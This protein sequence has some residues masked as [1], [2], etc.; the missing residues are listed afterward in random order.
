MKD[1]NSVT[2]TVVIAELSRKLA[3]EIQLGNEPQRDD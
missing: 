3:Q 1:E 2:P